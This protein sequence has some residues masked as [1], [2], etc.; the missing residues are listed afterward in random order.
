MTIPRLSVILGSMT[1]CLMLMAAY[2]DTSVRFYGP[3]FSPRDVPFQFQLLSVLMA[4][5]PALWMPI[6]ITRPSQVCY[7][8]LYLTVIIPAMFLPHQ[9]LRIEPDKVWP[10]VVALWTAFA[11]LG[12]PYG[13]KELVFRPIKVQATL[14]YA[15]L[16]G[17]AIV[18]IGTIAAITG[19]KVDLSL[20][21][22]YDRRLEARSSAPKGGLAS[23]ASGFLG[24]SIAPLLFSLSVV[25]RSMVLLTV[26]LMGLVTVFSLTGLKSVFFTPFLLLALY[27]MLRKK[28]EKFGPVLVWSAVALAV[29]ALI[30]RSVYGSYFVSLAFV[31]RLCFTPGMLHALYWDFFSNH[32]HVYLSDS[33]LSPLI[34]APYDRNVGPLMGKE[35]Y[36]SET[37]NATTGIWAQGFAHF[38]YSGIFM[39]SLFAGLL[40][41]LFDAAAKNRN[42]YVAGMIMGLVGVFWAN[43]AL[44]TSLLSNGILLSLLLL[45]VMPIAKRQ[46][47]SKAA[48]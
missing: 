11:L 19:F 20:A 29:I 48:A 41:A 42:F 14:Y 40:F 12:I 9:V 3:A 15:T 10:L 26:S 33:I 39:A 2:G 32:P 45:Y 34:T 28:Q 22:V 18:L 13:W 8:F 38:G 1:F 23:Y 21:T 27:Y 44:H 4:T 30:E 6:K 24:N 31:H 16:V 35:Y 7:W 5:S 43:V 25:N 47:T 17:I 36:A 37:M 46:P